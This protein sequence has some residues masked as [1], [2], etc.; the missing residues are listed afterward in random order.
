M[1]NDKDLFALIKET[2][3]LNPR[4]EFIALTERKLRQSARKIEKRKNSTWNSFVASG[5]VLCAITL[6]WIFLFS[7]KE[8]IINNLNSL[9]EG[10]ASS[11]VEEKEPTVY[12]YHSHNWES[13]VEET[14]AKDPN[15]AIHETRNI[16]IVGEMLSQALKEKN[17]N[18]I[19][20]KTNISNILKER[21]LTSIDSFKVSREALIET[22]KKNKSIK[23]VFDIHRDAH[24]R[25]ITTINIDGKDYARIAFVISGET[26]NFKKN[27]DFA[28]LIHQ[29]L[30]EKYPGL[31]RGVLTQSGG[32]QVVYNQDLLYNSLLLEIG[33]FE[34]TLEEES[35]TVEV[36]AD[37]IK[38]LIEFEK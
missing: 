12:I 10:V 25:S 31:S 19:H 23:M 26:N 22:L 8:V 32:I 24:Q 29:K 18:A 17:I 6:S 20:D 15:E 4:K 21:G 11:F 27:K 7:G 33:G 5:F 30:E 16:S 34:N 3:P 9:G 38:E 13:F 14:N 28:M 1:E 37:V 35:R 36:I 2:Y